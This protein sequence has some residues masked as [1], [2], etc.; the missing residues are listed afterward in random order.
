MPF[1]SLFLLIFVIITSNSKEGELLK[2]SELKKGQKA[3]V[4]SIEGNKEMKQRLLSFGL[5]KGSVVELLDCSLSKSNIEIMVDT[6]L[7]ALR[8]QEAE[9][10]EV[11][12]I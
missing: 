8:R 10:I 7:L 4:K 12:I 6:T 9:N 5:T 2:L 1:L 3:I 11:E